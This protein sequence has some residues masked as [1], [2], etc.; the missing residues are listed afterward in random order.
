MNNALRT[1]SR[2]GGFTLLEIAVATVIIAVGLTALMSTMRAGTSANSTSSK[3]TTAL[4]LSQNVH[5]W[6]RQ[7]P[8]AGDAAVVAPADP[9]NT[10]CVEE[11]NGKTFSPPRDGTGMPI[12]GLSEW[13]QS[14]TMSWREPEDLLLKAPG[15]SAPADG[16]TDMIH[17]TVDIQY[18]GAT[19]YTM[20]YFIFDNMV[21]AMYD[22]TADITPNPGG[23][24]DKID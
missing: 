17:V 16:A 7:L 22:P 13:S 23:I 15:A 14:I 8:L 3:L 24:G 20:R 1:R 12:T 6:T 5:E 11:L 21:P 9:A 18:R 19:V 2:R 4:F 10:T